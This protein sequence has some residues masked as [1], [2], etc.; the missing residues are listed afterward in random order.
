[1]LYRE[2]IVVY[3]EIRTKHIHAV[4]GQNVEFFNAKLGG[5]HSNHWDLQDSWSAGTNAPFPRC[6]AF[7]FPAVGNNSR[8]EAVTTDRR[9]RTSCQRNLQWTQDRPE[10]VTRIH[11]VTQ[12]HGAS[13][14]GC[15][16]VT[17]WKTEQHSKQ[18]TPTLPSAADSSSAGQ[19]RRR[20]NGIWRWSTAPDVRLSQLCWWRFKS[21]TILRRVDGS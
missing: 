21:P 1:M 14:G 4:C 3:S 15:S 2:I 16:W 11:A 12:T 18:V 7:L 10:K 20:F 9:C 5:T 13:L 8:D 17:N 19:E 6:L